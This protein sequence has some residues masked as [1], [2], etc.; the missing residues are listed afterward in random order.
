VVVIIKEI[1]LPFVAGTRAGTVCHQGERGLHIFLLDTTVT[2]AT[3]TITTPSRVLLLLLLLR[4]LWLLLL[5]L[6]QV[7]GSRGI[8]GCIRDG[9][10]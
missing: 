7:L 9:V 8:A 1:G 6:L 5:L 10:G 4:L 3:T 2:A